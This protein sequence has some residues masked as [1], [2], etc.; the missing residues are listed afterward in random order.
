MGKVTVVGGRV[1]MEAPKGINPVFAN[2]DWETIIEVVQKNKVPATWVVGDSKPMTINGK[3]YNIDIIGKNHDVYSDGSGIAPITFQ[4]HECYATTYA[5][6]SSNNNSGG[7]E[8]STVR[9][10]TVSTVFGQMPSEVQSAI[11]KVNKE[12][13]GGKYDYNLHTT[14]DTL[15]LL[16][17]YELWGTVDIS[18][19]VEGKHYA[20][21]AAGNSKIKYLLGTTSGSSQWWERSPTTDNYYNYAQV[22]NGNRGTN[23]ATNKAGLAFAFCF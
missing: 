12:T 20:Y 23:G 13:Y 18:R 3:E 4:M 8:N 11:R 2:N 14:A 16:S 1:G 17:E 10:S 19:G 15:F 7:W 5:M 9:L 21:Y 22:I 6:Y